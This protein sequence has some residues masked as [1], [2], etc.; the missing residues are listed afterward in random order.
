MKHLMLLILIARPFSLIAQSE[1]QIQHLSIH[2]TDSVECT[3]IKDQS[4]SPTCWV[5]GTNSLFEGDLIKRY[6][7]KLNL[8]EMFVARYAYVDKLNKYLAT[9]FR[10]RT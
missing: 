5:F 10:Y 8:S 1:N 6:G 2:L 9:N 7:I 4:R 3:E